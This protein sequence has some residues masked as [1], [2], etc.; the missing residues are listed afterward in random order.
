MWRFRCRPEN[1]I[2]LTVENAENEHQVKREKYGSCK[3]CSCKAGDILTVTASPAKNYK[4]S[5][6]KVN[7]N[8]LSGGSYIVSDAVPDTSVVI[9][10]GLRTAAAAPAEAAV[11]AI[12]ERD[13]KL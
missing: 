6:V 4:V 1:Q 5:A 13:R 7:G 12:V 11:A 10:A 8:V 2:P 9:S 3:R